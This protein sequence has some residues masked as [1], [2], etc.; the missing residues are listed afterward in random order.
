MERVEVCIEN[1]VI[2]LRYFVKDGNR[3]SIACR[4][5]LAPNVV[6]IEQRCAI[7]NLAGNCRKAFIEFGRL[8]AT[9]G[10]YAK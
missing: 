10:F 6:L 4:L 2:T 3:R 5:E 7:D 1:V 9:I 8:K